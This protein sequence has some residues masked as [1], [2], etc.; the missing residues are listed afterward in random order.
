MQWKGFEEKALHRR[1]FFIL[2][3]LVISLWSLSVTC[4][5]AQD[6][7]EFDFDEP[8]LKDPFW[9]VVPERG[10]DSS[11]FDFQ[12]DWTNWIPDTV[13]YDAGVKISYVSI[14]QKKGEDYLKFT[15]HERI[16]LQIELHNT[17][18]ERVFWTD[19]IF[20]AGVNDIKLEQTLQGGEYKLLFFS[21][22]ESVVY[23]ESFRR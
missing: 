3:L 7:Y 10:G 21:D 12:S 14:R 11:R 22:N 2:R 4:V 23:L 6:Q 16:Y 17:P 15:L 13:N 9:E 8:T 20:R 5:W 18:G 1:A 19:G